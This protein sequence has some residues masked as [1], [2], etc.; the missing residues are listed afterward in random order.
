MTFTPELLDDP[1]VFRLVEARNAQ[2]H[3]LIGVAHDMLRQATEID[4]SNIATEIIHKYPE[5]YFVEF[6]ADQRTDFK[7]VIFCGH[8]DDENGKRIANSFEAKDFVEA[9]LL[10]YSIPDRKA[11]VERRINLREY[12]VKHP[13]W[14]AL[15]A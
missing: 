12:A 4:L 10:D 5:A 3:S 8:I 1:E 13:S 9:L 7:G 6:I 15:R 11:I 2:S 14:F